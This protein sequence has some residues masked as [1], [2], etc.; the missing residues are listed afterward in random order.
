MSSTG[1]NQFSISLFNFRFD[2]YSGMSFLRISLALSLSLAIL[3]EYAMRRDT[4]A[5]QF[6]QVPFRGKRLF[7]VDRVVGNA[8]LSFMC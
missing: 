4:A 1:G 7:E 2:T 3:I 6:E 5:P 8:N